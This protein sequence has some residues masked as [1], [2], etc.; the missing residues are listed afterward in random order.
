MIVLLPFFM[1]I[2][3]VPFLF[4]FLQLFWLVYHPM[5]A[6]MVL[7]C[8]SD[9]LTSLMH[10]LAE[11]FTTWLIIDFLHL[12]SYHHSWWLQYIAYPEYTI[13]KAYLNFLD[14]L[15]TSLSHHLNL[16]II[17]VMTLIL[18]SPPYFWKFK[19]NIQISHTTS[20]SS[21]DLLFFRNILLPYWEFSVG[22]PW[23]SY[24]LPFWG[25]EF[26]LYSP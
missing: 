12:C 15:M 8:G 17:R 18:S 19:S 21:S 25:H 23:P 26:L 22:L 11:D 14:L 16:T 6:T 7:L 20:T 13:P 3:H 4:Q 5:R 9:S 10:L 1:P 24:Q 2:S